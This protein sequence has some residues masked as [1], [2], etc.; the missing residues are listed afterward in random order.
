MLHAFKVACKITCKIACKVACKIAC[1][2]PLLFISSPEPRCVAFRRMCVSPLLFHHFRCPN[3]ISSCP[4]RVGATAA[5]N[6]PPPPLGAQ[7]PLKPSK[8]A[9]YLQ[10]F[11]LYV[12]WHP[13]GAFL[14]PKWSPK[15][16]KTAPEIMFLSHLEFSSLFYT[17]RTEKHKFLDPS[18]LD[19][20]SRTLCF[21]V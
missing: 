9:M 8:N 3:V 12:F 11:F 4:Q 13:F 14:M 21:T 7:S 20:L 6:L 2:I 10:V 15:C 19:F 1:K 18:D 17:H 5:G 16:S